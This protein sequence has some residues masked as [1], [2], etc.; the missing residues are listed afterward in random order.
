MVLL[1]LVMLALVG[2]GRHVYVECPA[3]VFGASCKN[4]FINEQGF[5]TVDDDELC[6]IPILLPGMSYGEPEPWLSENFG[7]IC[8]V[9]V[10]I[11]FALNHVLY[12]R[13][14]KP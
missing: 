14:F 2:T 8:L 10:L 6:S 7:L 5:C 9:V 12:N 11:A 1:F 4:P 3:D 13:R